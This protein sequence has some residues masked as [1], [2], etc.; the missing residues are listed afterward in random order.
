MNGDRGMHDGCGFGVL[1]CLNRSGLKLEYKSNFSGCFLPS[2]CP[3]SQNLLANSVQIRDYLRYK[4]SV[5]ISLLKYS[6]YTPLVMVSNI[7]NENNSS[8]KRNS[9]HSKS[10]ND[11]SNSTISKKD[12][13]LLDKDHKNEDSTL[14]ELYLEGGEKTEEQIK[15]VGKKRGVKAGTRLSEEHKMKIRNGMRRYF[16]VNPDAEKTRA[17]LS[18]AKRGRNNPMYK[19]QHNEQTRAKM[20]ALRS[21]KN[22]PNYGKKLSEDTKQKIRESM[23]K[24]WDARRASIQK[25]ESEES[26][27]ER[28][29]ELRLKKFGSAPRT[30]V[31][32][33]TG[34]GSE[35]QT[36]KK[37]KRR[38]KSIKKL[39]N[40]LSVIRSST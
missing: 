16:D 35:Y 17:L 22:N 8:R 14:V 5:F 1:G 23:K 26:V 28:L 2:T 4:R 13:D 27:Q 7:K 25:E 40:L 34:K 36:R 24:Y 12:S 18:K 11:A 21:G 10:T 9:I 33:G 6:H 30:K 19:K 39:A 32:T 29:R 38:E 15:K 3:K 31:S 20:S 37:E